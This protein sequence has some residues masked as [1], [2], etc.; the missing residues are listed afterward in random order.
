MAQG[1]QFLFCPFA[2]ETTK[3]ALHWGTWGHQLLV[4]THLNRLLFSF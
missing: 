2:K 3:L 1:D 4:F